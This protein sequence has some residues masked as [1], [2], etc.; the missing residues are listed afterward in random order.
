[1]SRPER[2][3]LLTGLLFLSPWLIGLLVFT[4]YPIVT[5]LYYSLTDFTV[6]RPP[7]WVGLA[8]YAYLL[9][10]DE[11]FWRFAVFNTLYMFLELPISI[12]M[13]VGLAMLLNQRLRG[14]ALF[15]TV[16][17]LPVLVP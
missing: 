6:L 4:A 3:R 14:M 13:G 10:G 12:T 9:T 15:R 2:S 11:Y 7:R 8:N 5:S 1:M 16:F 17:Y